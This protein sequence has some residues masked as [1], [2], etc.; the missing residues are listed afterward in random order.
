MLR[1]AVLD[2]E[3]HALEHFESVA[4]ELDGIELCGL[5]DDAD[6]LI[7]CIEDNPPDAVFLDIEMPGR[8]GM[9][10]A[11]ELHAIDPDLSIVFVTAFS[12]YAVEAF[13]LSVSDYLMKP[14]SK[15]RLRRTL[16]RIAGSKQSMQKTEKRVMIQCFRRF[17]LRI[18]GRVVALNH[19][20]KAKELLAFLVSREGAETSWEQIT[21]ALWPEADYER[22]HNNLYV[23]TF[24]LRK[25]L[26]ENGITRIFESRR[27][28]YRVVLTEFNCDLFDL[29]KALKDGNEKKIRELY[30]GDFLE[31]EAY[32]WAYPVQ[33]A[34]AGKLKHK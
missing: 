26:E 23:T 5:F 31:E 17:E 14:V 2:D 20:M 15:E 12:Q 9:Q 27:N 10:L 4:G 34:W 33:A 13:E 32:G 25:W 18:E 6:D 19:L 21:E 3:N 1:I 30:Q 11:E 24:R 8:S 29:E 22:A 7:A 28:S 16:N